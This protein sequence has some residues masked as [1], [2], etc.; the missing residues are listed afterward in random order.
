MP[1]DYNPHL[2]GRIFDIKKFAV[3]DGPGIRT[4]IFMKGCFL[5]CDWCHN[6]ESIRPEPQLVF[7]GDKCISCSNCIEACQAGAKEGTTGGA[8]YL[9]YEDGNRA[10]PENLIE[11]RKVVRRYD[12]DKC[13]L[14][15]AC[16]ERCYPEAWFMW[17]RMISVG[18][19]YKELDKDRPFYENSNGGITVSG[20][21][22]LRQHDFVGNLLHMCKEEGLHTALDTSGYSK[23][24][25]F[26]AVLPYT[27]LVLLDLKIMDSERHRQHT[28][29][30]NGL[31]LENA[32]KM[33]DLENTDIWVRVPLIPGINSDEDNIAAIAGFVRESMPGATR[34]VEFLPYHRLGESKFER[35]GRKYKLKGVE[36]P[37]KEMMEQIVEIAERELRKTGIEV[38]CEG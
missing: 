10:D 27:N 31:I 20:G 26:E 5:D 28:G 32:A 22:P 36:P 37:T 33:A 23:W 35:L 30:D 8:L 38:K 11:G 16:V 4:T 7:Y 14:D 19:A 9:A 15:G 3:H 1:E 6:P 21:E 18:D 29:V 2:E 12:I 13:T 24:E 25:K 34:R 17:G